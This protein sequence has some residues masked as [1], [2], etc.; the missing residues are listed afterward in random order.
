MTTLATLTLRLARIV[1]DVVDGTATGGNATTIADT[2]NLVQANDYWNRGTVWILSGNNQ[3]KVGIVTDF[4]NSTGT[5]TFATMTTLNAAGNRFAVA[6]GVYPYNVLV[7]KIMAALDETYV[8]SDGS[9]VLPTA[10]ITGDGTE[11]EFTLPAGVSRVS[12]V[13]LEDGSDETLTYTSTHWREEGG[14]L[15]FDPG[16]PP[17]DDYIIHPYYRTSHT[18]L[19][20]ATDTLSDQINAEWLVWKAAE[21]VLY[22]GVQNY[23]EAKEYK[24]EELMNRVLNKQKGIYPRKPIFIVRTAGG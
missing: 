9:P 18:E 7:S 24:I 11:L 14:V 15:K 13:I 12:K 23:G 1:T 16:Y 6:R 22:W 20:N 19:V 2:A 10:P 4:V 8:I 5:L 3:G 17:L 21:Y